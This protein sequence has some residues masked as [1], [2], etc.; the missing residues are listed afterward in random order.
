MMENRRRGWNVLR[1][2]KRLLFKNMVREGLVDLWPLSR[3]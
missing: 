1:L 2:E 3:A